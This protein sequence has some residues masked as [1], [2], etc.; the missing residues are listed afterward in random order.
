MKTVFLLS[1]QAVPQCLCLCLVLAQFGVGV[2][3]EPFRRSVSIHPVDAPP[4]SKLWP[5]TPHPLEAENKLPRS[6]EVGPSNTQTLHVGSHDSMSCFCYVCLCHVCVLSSQSGYTSRQQ[7]SVRDKDP[8]SQLFI[9]PLIKAT[10][11]ELSG[12]LRGFVVILEK[13]L[14]KSRN[15]SKELCRCS[16]TQFSS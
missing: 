10:H 7:N 1:I 3:Q 15:W 13:T 14:S 2:V 11:L 16:K 6:T 12:G 8:D 9:S 5:F 4:G